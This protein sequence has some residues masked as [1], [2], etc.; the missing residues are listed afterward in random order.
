[1]KLSLGKKGTNEQMNVQWVDTG[2]SWADHY[3]DK[4]IPD[5]VLHFTW[6]EILCN[7]CCNK[8]KVSLFL[9]WGHFA[10][11]HSYILAQDII[12]K[13]IHTMQEL[14]FLKTLKIHV[15]FLCHR[16]GRGKMIIIVMENFIKVCGRVESVSDQFSIIVVCWQ[17]NPFSAWVAAMQQQNWKTELHGNFLETLLRLFVKFSQNTLDA[18]FKHPWNFHKTSLKLPWTSFKT[19]F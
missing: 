4:C 18:F 15:S 6:S 2:N 16:K 14:F 7:K 5:P 13:E 1:M 10:Q 19:P 12:H 17:T 11:Y 9:P 3:S 8:R